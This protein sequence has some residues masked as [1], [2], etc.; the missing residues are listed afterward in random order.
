[1]T[2]E[3][4]HQLH[5][6]AIEAG[7]AD[8]R[9]ALLAKVD[10]TVVNALPN[11]DV[12]SDQLLSDLEHLDQAGALSTGEI[13]LQV[14][15][16]NAAKAAGKRTQAEIFKSFL[17]PEP[18]K[19][20]APSGASASVIV[21]P[22]PGAAPRFKGRILLGSVAA[23]AAVVALVVVVKQCDAP[24]QRVVFEFVGRESADSGICNVSTIPDPMV[25]HSLYHWKVTA[26]GDGASG[27]FRLEVDLDS[28][29]FIPERWF[30]SI[31][32]TPFVRISA[33]R[34]EIPGTTMAF[35]R[36]LDLDVV[37]PAAGT[38][39]LDVGVCHYEPPQIPIKGPL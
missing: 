12:P 13:P 33:R 37:L 21:P 29:A 39:R 27:A 9:S 15:L 38:T 14:W 30:Q 10:E 17:D 7:L 18:A 28:D 34:A 8:R 16:R 31:S 5:N 25:K 26:P 3:Q 1:L 20:S 24:D 19:Q 23:V 6:A 22:V 4:L 2:H 36:G 11:R 32:A 35:I